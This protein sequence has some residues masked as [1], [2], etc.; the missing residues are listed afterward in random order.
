MHSNAH[1]GLCLLQSQVH[2]RG[3]SKA[4]ACC[5]D[6]AVPRC[7]DAALYIEEDLMCLVDASRLNF[8]RKDVEPPAD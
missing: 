1:F 8:Q 2:R 3:K 7:L 5:E 6:N 4:Q